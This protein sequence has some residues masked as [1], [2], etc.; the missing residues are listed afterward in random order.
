MIWS[1]CGTPGSLSQESSLY[2]C[3]YTG[4]P[5][6]CSER[7]LDVQKMYITTKASFSRIRVHWT[8]T[9]WGQLIFLRIIFEGVVSEHAAFSVSFFSLSVSKSSQSCWYKFPSQCSGQEE[10]GLEEK[11]D[12]VQSWVGRASIYKQVCSE[13]KVWTVFSPWNFFNLLFLQN[14][15]C[16]SVIFQCIKLNEL[17]HK[18][19]SRR[20][21]F[22]FYLALDLTIEG[23][24]QTFLLVLG[25]QSRE[26]R[27]L[28]QEAS[29][30]C[31]I[32]F[33][34]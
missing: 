2:S 12:Y 29:D 24:G 30:T 33:F 23:I 17:V 16:L 6:Y 5:R 3:I 34:S 14:L 32:I 28:S 7:C 1:M 31:R 13:K 22:C 18:A 9:F 15:R 26:N 11:A 27:D 21:F 8:K 20:M 4:W 19:E 10:H 25:S